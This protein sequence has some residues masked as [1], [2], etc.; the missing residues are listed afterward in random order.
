[1]D[2]YFLPLINPIETIFFMHLIGT[3]WSFCF[4]LFFCFCFCFFLI[5]WNPMELI[6]VSTI[7]LSFPLGSG[8]M[9][10]FDMNI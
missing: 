2:F 5:K 4:V 7:A 1:M 3:Q 8:I 10:P 9:G 6:P